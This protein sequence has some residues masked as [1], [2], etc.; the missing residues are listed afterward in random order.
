MA[1]VNVEH[2]TVEYTNRRKERVTAVS[3]VSFCLQPGHVTAVVGYSGSGKTTL[4]KSLAG[5]LPYRGNIYFDGVELSTIGI[6]DRSIALAQQE[7]AL[8]PNMTVF[9][10]IAT[11]LKIRGVDKK[12]IIRRVN[13]VAEDLQ[14]AVCL[15][16]KPRCISG[17]QQQRVALA[18]ALITRSSV[19]LLD[20]PLSNIAPD[21]RALLRAYIKQKVR[22][23]ATA[24][25]YV[26]HDLPE[27]VSLADH[28]IVMDEGRI[29]IEGKPV[30]VFHSGNHVVEMLKQGD[31]KWI[32]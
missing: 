25:V 21:Q 6:E 5:L 8:Y 9:D 1:R 14:I 7:Y 18:R 2:L 3:D 31:E 23:Y 19:L 12:E 20:E 11:P 27:A 10:N 30:E 15:T 24:A 22:H 32:R 16:R 13:A 29:V 28:L 17:G 4:L 26:T